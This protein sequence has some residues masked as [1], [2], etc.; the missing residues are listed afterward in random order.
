MIKISF[1]LSGMIRTEV[2]IRSMVII[3]I[4]TH[5]VLAVINFIDTNNANTYHS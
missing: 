4:S 1:T 5:K 3:I 2:V